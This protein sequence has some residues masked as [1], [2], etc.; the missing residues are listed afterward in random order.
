M[1]YRI[2]VW[3]R[4]SE[5]NEIASCLEKLRKLSKYVRGKNT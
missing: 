3:V 1:G 5:R 4:K 2:E